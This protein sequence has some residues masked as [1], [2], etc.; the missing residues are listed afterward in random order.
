MASKRI[1]KWG[2]KKID[3]VHSKTDIRIVSIALR[4]AKFSQR[5]NLKSVLLTGALPLYPARDLGGPQTLCL[6]GGLQPPVP[7]TQFNSP[8]TSNH[9]DNPGCFSVQRK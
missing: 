1:M 2:I 5:E 4:R 9:S 3:D 8:A 7:P 6:L